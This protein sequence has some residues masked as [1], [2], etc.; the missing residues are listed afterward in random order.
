MAPSLQFRDGNLLVVAL[1]LVK[2]IAYIFEQDES[3]PAL[4]FTKLTFCQYVYF[5]I[6]LLFW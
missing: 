3:L 4:G 6:I 2:P 5:Y 1:K